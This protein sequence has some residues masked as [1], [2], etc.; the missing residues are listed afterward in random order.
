MGTIYKKKFCLFHALWS[1]MEVTLKRCFVILHKTS[2]PIDSV[3][4]KE[5]IFLGCVTF[6]YYGDLNKQPHLEVYYGEILK[7]WGHK[8]LTISIHFVPY[9]THASSICFYV[10]LRYY[11]YKICFFICKTHIFYNKML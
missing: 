5:V 4:L 9:V 8:M 11:M 10:K 2:I 6:H 7:T 1:Y 3:R